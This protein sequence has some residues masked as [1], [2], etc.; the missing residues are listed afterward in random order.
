MSGRQHMRRYG[1]AMLLVGVVVGMAGLAFASVPLYRL[2]CQ[3][4]GYGDRKGVG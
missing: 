2:F 4:T 3:V 1:T